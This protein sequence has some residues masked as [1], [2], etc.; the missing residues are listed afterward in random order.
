MHFNPLDLEFRGA[1][2]KIKNVTPRATNLPKFRDNYSNCGL[3]LVLLL[4]AFVRV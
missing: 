4:S 2:Y 3:K 1:R